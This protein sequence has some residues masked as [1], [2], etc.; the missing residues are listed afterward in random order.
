MLRRLRRGRRPAEE[1]ANPHRGRPATPTV[2]PAP[3][4][5]PAMA[6]WLAKLGGKRKNWRR[7]W[8]VLRGPDLSYWAPGAGKH[9]PAADTTAA[10]TATGTQKGGVDLGL[11]TSVGRAPPGKRSH[12][13][14]LHSPGRVFHFQVGCYGAVLGC[15]ARAGC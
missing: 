4:L 10:I 12:V 7:R 11:I 15:G 3:E 6:G 13:I 9:A 5:A 8:F 2:L 1:D 14:L